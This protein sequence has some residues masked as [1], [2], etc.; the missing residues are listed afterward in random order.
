MS[1]PTAEDPV[2]DAAAAPD[3][4]FLSGKYISPLPVNGTVDRLTTGVRLQSNRGR[5]GKMPI[6]GRYEHTAETA[7]RHENCW[8]FTGL[9]SRGLI[10]HGLFGRWLAE[11]VLRDEEETMREQFAE[12]GGERRRR[13]AK[14]FT[15]IYFLTHLLIQLD[16][17]CTVD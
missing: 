14:I 11:S 6:V 2:L 4:A 17:E 8:I 13:K 16:I 3:E 7:I 10:Y 12:I 9:S 5:F 15:V 1:L